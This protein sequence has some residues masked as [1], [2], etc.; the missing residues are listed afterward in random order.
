[1]CMVRLTSEF[2]LHGLV[3]GDLHHRAREPHLIQGV[4]VDGVLDDAACQ[5]LDHAGV[6][7]GQLPVQRAQL[8]R[9]AT[10]A[11]RYS[12]RTNTVSAISYSTNCDQLTP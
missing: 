5:Q 10:V 7:H 4:L 8:I 6:V 11:T 3:Q 9:P 2:A 1:M 12:S